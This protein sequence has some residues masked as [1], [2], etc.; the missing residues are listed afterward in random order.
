MASNLGHRALTL[1]LCLNLFFI[2]KA[3]TLDTKFEE[4]DSTIAQD[5][6]QISLLTCTPGPQVY[7]LYGHMAIRYQIISWV[8][9]R[10]NIFIGIILVMVQIL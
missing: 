2:L 3:Q 9:F 5:S 8:E 7:A 6:I 10:M 4:P 1:L